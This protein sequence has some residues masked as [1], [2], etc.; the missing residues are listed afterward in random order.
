MLIELRMAKIIGDNIAP[1]PTIET[2]FKPR[3]TNISHPEGSLFFSRFKTE[4]SHVI[5][6][7]AKPK[8]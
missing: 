3:T 4:A 8:Q 7:M 6:K 2:E 1:Y 5:E